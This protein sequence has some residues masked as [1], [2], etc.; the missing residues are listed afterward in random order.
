MEFETS[1]LEM[2]LCE[3]QLLLDPHFFIESLKSELNIISILI[4]VIYT[5]RGE[6]KFAFK[7][8]N[9]EKKELRNYFC[10]EFRPFNGKL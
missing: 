7:V 9:D 3:S 6:K 2:I 1:E 10:L 8:R 4:K 5:K